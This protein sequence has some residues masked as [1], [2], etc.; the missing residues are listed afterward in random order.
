MYKINYRSGGTAYSP[1][2]NSAAVYFINDCKA[3][4]EEINKAEKELQLFITEQQKSFLINS[5]G[6]S[7]RTFSVSGGP[8]VAI[9]K[10]IKL[11]DDF[12][13]D[14]FRDYFSLL[15]GTL[16]KENTDRLHVLLPDLS[17]FEKYFNSPADIVSSIV[18]GLE[19]GN[20]TFDKY[21]SEKK[22]KK[23]L[24]VILYGEKK[25]V[26][27][28]IKKAGNI[29][30]GVMLARELANEPSSVVTPA[31]LARRVKKN[32]TKEGVKVR[33]LDEKELAQRSMGGIL[34]VGKGSENPP[35]LII[36]T[37]KGKRSKKK[38]VLVGKG[39]TFDS[40]GISIKPSAGMSEM[41]ADMSGAA[42]VAGAVLAAARAG[43]HVDITGIIPA[44]ENMPSGSAL[45]PGDIVITS[46]G[47]SIE[48]DNTDAEGRIILAD[49]LEL[50]AKEKGDAVI[51]LATLTGACVVALGEYTAGLFTKSDELADMLT[52][53]ADS[54]YERVWRLPMW[55]E[56]K[57]LIKS[58]VADVKNVGG[59]WG[60]AITAAKFLEYFADKDIPWA[61]LDIAGP[62]MP[63]NL[64]NYSQKYMTGF[65]VRLLFEFLSRQ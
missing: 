62:A 2:E 5:D 55:D 7:I 45:K 17:L 27:E 1:A 41:K 35:R 44:V 18:E 9:L 12:S 31:E 15:T 10:K 24:S 23:Q 26:A 47:K 59:R 25:T 8:S 11:S 43:L 20:Y 19:L 63:N 50:A 6:D 49:A 38:I 37:Y 58:D 40:G 61:H 13:S 29:I 60:G 33:I 36:M 57:K 34:A 4:S 16:E 22:K 39:V 52:K 28:G 3:L 65:G 56:Y 30:E 32:L 64:N 42:A 51:D 21:K 14:F 46:S 54:T 53:A 48:V